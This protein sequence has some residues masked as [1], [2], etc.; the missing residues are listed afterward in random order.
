MPWSPAQHR[1]FEFVAHN[2]S[3]AASEGI[4]IGQGQAQKMASEGIKQKAMAKVLKTS[5]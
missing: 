2:P 4:K 1:L 3:K 5:K